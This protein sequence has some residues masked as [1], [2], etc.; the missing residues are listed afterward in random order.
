[1]IPYG[2]QTDSSTFSS[3]LRVRHKKFPTNDDPVDDKHAV[4]NPNESL[5]TPNLMDEYTRALVCKA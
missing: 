2:V 1:M 4:I 5:V 3:H